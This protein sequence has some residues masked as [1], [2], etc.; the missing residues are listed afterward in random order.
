MTY[1][2]E[3]VALAPD[4]KDNRQVRYAEFVDTLRDLKVGESF[5]FGYKFLS[6]HRLAITVVSRVLRHEYV[7]RKE[8]N[9]VRIGRIR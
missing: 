8:N 9:V 3:K 4:A 6:S 7:A 1:K 5:V 2:I